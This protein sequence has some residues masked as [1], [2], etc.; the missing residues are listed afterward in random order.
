[1]FMKDVRINPMQT[2][3]ELRLMMKR[4]DY[5][6]LRSLLFKSIHGI[7]SRLKMER[8]REWAYFK[9][10]STY[11]EE[12]FGFWKFAEDYLGCSFSKKALPTE[13]RT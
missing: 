2:D 6:R 8:L 10:L 13:N 3:C 5:D 1:M 7:A 11:C 9:W 12:A 4:S